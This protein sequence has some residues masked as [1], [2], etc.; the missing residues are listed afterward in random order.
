[1]GNA[2]LAWRTAKHADRAPE[3]LT[4]EAGIEDHHL[5]VHGPSLD[6]V[7]HSLMHTIVKALGGDNSPPQPRLA[8]SIFAVSPTLSCIELA[9]NGRAPDM[10]SGRARMETEEELSALSVRRMGGGLHRVSKAGRGVVYRILLPTNPA[11][12]SSSTQPSEPKPSS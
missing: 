9:H 10:R 12:Q 1:V 11:S 4:V 2:E 7:L 5:G 3:G 8:C 6:T